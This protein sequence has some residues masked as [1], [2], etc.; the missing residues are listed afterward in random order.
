MSS[1]LSHGVAQIEQIALA[2]N[3]LESLC[4]L[5]R[6]LGGV[7]LPR[8]AVNSRRCSQRWPRALRV[9]PEAPDGC[10]LEA[11]RIGPTRRYAGG[12]ATSVTRA[13]H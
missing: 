3:H 12:R 7:A 2:T 6:Q 5:Y 8:S 1:E 11:A 13:I 10:P 9:S 4:G